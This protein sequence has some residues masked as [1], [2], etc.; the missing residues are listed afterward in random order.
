MDAKQ[1][2]S[3]SDSVTM[4][5][6]KGKPE[7]ENTAF[8]VNDNDSNSGFEQSGNEATHEKGFSEVDICV[9]GEVMKMPEKKVKKIFLV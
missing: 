9:K 2:F 6:S 8:E 4:S 3:I 1:F 7:S 5:L